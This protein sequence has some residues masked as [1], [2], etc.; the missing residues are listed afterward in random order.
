MYMT[1]AVLSRLDRD[2][3]RDPRH[4]TTMEQE[5]TVGKHY[6]TLAFREMDRAMDGFFDNDDA[7]VGQVSDH[8]TGWK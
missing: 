1:A 7:E 4:T 2:L 6:C 3:G 8:I 5:L